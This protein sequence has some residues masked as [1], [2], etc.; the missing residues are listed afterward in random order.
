MSRLKQTHRSPDAVKRGLAPPA[1]R[2]PVAR[3]PAYLQSKMAVSRPGDAEERE[4]DQVA[5]QVARSPRPAP[6]QRAGLAPGPTG[7]EQS[8]AP[9]AAARAL[10]RQPVEEEEPLQ[11]R[12][13]RQA[14]PEEDEEEEELLMP[15]LGRQP[16]QEDEEPLQTRLWRQTMEEDEEPL[17]TLGR[18]PAEEEEPLQALRRQPAGEEEE[19]IQA[20][21]GR[22]AD[23]VAGQTLDPETERR[24]EARRG[25]GEPLAEDLRRDMEARFGHDFASVRIHTDAEAADLAAKL[26][27]RAFTVGRDVFFAA[28]EYAPQTD[29]GRE[30]LAHELTH[31]VQQGGGA[32][33]TVMRAED[34]DASGGAPGGDTDTEAYDRD[35]FDIEIHGQSVQVRVD[36][37]GGRIG[38]DSIPLPPYK[39]P[40]HSGRPLRHTAGQSRGD[41][42]E[43]DQQLSL[44][45]ESAAAAAGPVGRYV[46]DQVTTH[47]REPPRD[48]KN[49]AFSQH[50]AG[51]NRHTRRMIGPPATLV[52]ELVVPSWDAAGGGRWFN[53]DHRHELQLGGPATDV[54]NNMWLLDRGINQATGREIRR[55]IRSMAA[56]VGDHER[57]NPAQTPA[58]QGMANADAILANFTLSFDQPVEQTE[59]TGSGD[60]AYKQP[61]LAERH[62]WEYSDIT[63]GEHLQ[64]QGISLQLESLESLGDE[65]NVYVFP[66]EGGGVGRQFRNSERLY[67]GEDRWSTYLD[68]WRIT[69]KSFSTE[70]GSQTE[71]QL[72]HFTLAMPD[73][74]ATEP[75]EGVP[76]PI[77]R[78]RGS[79]YAG[80][81]SVTRFQAAFEELS[82]KHTSPIRITQFDLSQGGLQVHGRIEPTIP[83]VR[84]THLE[85][86]VED[87]Q[88]KIWKTFALGDFDVPS[89]FQVDDV[90]LTLAYGSR[91]ALTLEG[92]IDFGI[93]NLGEGHLE[94]AASSASGFALEGAFDFDTELFDPARAEMR[95]RDGQLSLSGEIG[96]P[97]GKVPGIAGATVT[98]DYTEGEGFTA[99]GEATLDIPGVERGTLNVSQSEAEGFSIGGTFQ[100]GNDIPGIRGGTLSATLRR[101]PEGEG[102]TVSAS[103]EAEPDIPGFDSTLAVRYQDGA[104]TLEA[105]AAYERGLLSGQVRF[106]ATNRTLDAEGNPTGEPGGELIA[107]GGGEVTLRIAP[108]LEGTAGI[109]FAPDG[110]VTVAGEIGLPDQIELFP[111]KEIR[112][113]VLSIDIPIP[114]G[115]GI[116]AE[117]G[118]GLDAHA[119]IGPGVIDQ[120]RLGVE[121]TPSREQDTRVTGDAHLNVPADAGLRLSVHAG[122]GLGIP[123]ASV[124]GGLEIGGELGLEGAAEAGVHID[125]MPSEGLEIDAFG[126]LSAQP[127]FT[128][129]V[130][131]YVE[132]EALFF[133]IY[134]ERWEL[135]SFELGSNL[136][137]GVRFPIHYRE[138]E[139]FDI[140]LDDVEFEVP[141]VS[142]RQILDDLMDEIT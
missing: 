123:A 79:R 66:F 68:P 36:H 104:I 141:D 112:K 115:P 47:L 37:G 15:R 6:L 133:T 101:R 48:S 82:A 78:Y 135:A 88:L 64:V 56:R 134:E 128:F 30:L 114:I 136:T 2:A 105:T 61:A 21:P 99:T 80:Y 70:P 75:R 107:Y 118:G 29:A 122:I 132:V 117:V 59:F 54:Q 67:S 50:P 16:T 92:R 129:D 28:G 33:R 49:Y 140:A 121:Y 106:G 24:I 81:L 38:F 45:K 25:M 138:G 127:K 130:S 62:R 83:L 35:R 55:T 87:G 110:E 34:G 131:G 12:L 137:F 120:L 74:R 72:G 97:R 102:Y 71:E 95:Y 58:R 109:R 26:G 113:D 18:Q 126:R 8:L 111:R 9:V 41:E 100:L 77:V 3:R 84:D 44:W 53:V 22:Q 52:R 124:S 96:I 139:P 27:A 19:P 10:A 69:A 116:F 60:A 42:E 31:V 86:G 108:W 103:G 46:S 11:T 43:N 4:A 40:L 1:R 98:A 73:N 91:D 93:E 14:D 13:L 5:A 65:E 17:Q 23:G 39:V 142:P 89:P 119:G 57:A 32:A 7:E 125:W 20:R 94:A 76:L 90:T 63:E 51:Y 85:F